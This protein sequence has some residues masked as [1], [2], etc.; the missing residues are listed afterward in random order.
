MNINDRKWFI[1]V[2]HG[3]PGGSFVMTDLQK[4]WLE[5]AQSGE[6]LVILKPRCSTGSTSISTLLASLGFTH[7]NQEGWPPSAESSSLERLG[8]T[9]SQHEPEGR[10]PSQEAE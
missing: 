2:D 7:Q 1:G 5:F 8:G 10:F 4:R 9:V 3:T 6:R